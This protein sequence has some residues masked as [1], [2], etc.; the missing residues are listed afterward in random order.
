MST[1]NNYPLFAADQVLKAEHL[2]ELFEYLDQDHRLTRRCFLGMGIVCGLDIHWSQNTLFI[3]SGLASTSEGYKIS[4][5]ASQFTHYR[6]YSLPEDFQPNDDTENDY[7]PVYGSLEFKRLISAKDK[8]SSDK[9]ISSLGAEMNRWAV[10][11]FLE[12]LETDLKNCTTTDCDDKGKKVVNTTIWGVT[13]SSIILTARSGRAALAYR[14]KKIGYELTKLQLDIV[15]LEFVKVADRKKEVIDDD[16]HQ[17][18]QKYSK[19]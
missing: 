12:R 8:K 5:E 15:Y 16:V 13:D 19:F 9:T 4:L 17:I 14:A 18:I 6:S 3:S 2:N 11:L 1:T 7:K 10:M